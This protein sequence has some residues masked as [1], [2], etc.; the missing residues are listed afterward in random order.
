MAKVINTQLRAL[1]YEILS[2][3]LYEIFTVNPV[4]F[5]FYYPHL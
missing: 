2:G 4:I 5:N 1:F 3:L